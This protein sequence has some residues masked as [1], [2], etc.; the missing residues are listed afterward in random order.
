MMSDE[1][2]ET[3]PPR[4]RKIYKIYEISRSRRKEQE[5]T[6]EKC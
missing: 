5:K 2:T 4:K 1:L 3:C 6:G